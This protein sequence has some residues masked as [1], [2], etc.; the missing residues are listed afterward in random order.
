MA[1]SSVT[2]DVLVCP[3]KR[4]NSAQGC[5][6]T[7]APRRHSPGQHMPTASIVTSRDQGAPAR[8]RARWAAETHH[9]FRNPNGIGRRSAERRSGLAELLKR[10]RRDAE[11][12]VSTASSFGFRGNNPRNSRFTGLSTSGAKPLMVIPDVRPDD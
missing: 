2:L 3:S 7:G 6:T 8:R 1:S 11:P 9:F 10:W 5:S 4:K 12:C